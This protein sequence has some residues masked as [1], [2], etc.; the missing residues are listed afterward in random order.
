MQKGVLL[1]AMDEAEGQVAS[2][3][4]PEQLHAHKDAIKA[5]YKTTL[6]RACVS[7]GDVALR[8]IC[9]RRGHATILDF[10]RAQQHTS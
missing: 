7:H 8:N 9:V 2:S 6:W 3:L 1:M 5:A 4:P 10:G